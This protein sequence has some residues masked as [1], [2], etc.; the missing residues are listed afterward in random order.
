MNRLL[1]KWRRNRVGKLDAENDVP[2]PELPGC[3]QNVAS[4]RNRAVPS[5]GWRSSR[6]F[7]CRRKSPGKLRDSKDTHALLA[8]PRRTIQV[9]SFL[10]RAGLAAEITE[11]TA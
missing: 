4:A 3:G 1:L 7:W 6:K 11:V 8:R 5:M 2:E 10:S 9:P